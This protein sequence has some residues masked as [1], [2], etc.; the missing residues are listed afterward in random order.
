M[1]NRWGS[2]NDLPL[3]SLRGTADAASRCRLCVQ[4]DFAK[5]T[6]DPRRVFDAA[7]LLIDGFEALDGAVT[8]GQLS[9]QD[10][11]RLEDIE[12][13]SL[14]VWIRNLLERVDDRDLREGEW[15]KI[16]GKALFGLDF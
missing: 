15:K 1:C 10:P 11:Y 14:K 2:C 7:V 4:I 6:G 13:G 9:D 8:T 12:A 3:D 5:G 16:V